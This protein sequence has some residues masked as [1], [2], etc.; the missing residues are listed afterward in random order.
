MSSKFTCPRPRRSGL[1]SAQQVEQEADAEAARTLPD[2]IAPETPCRAG[3]VQVGPGRVPDELRQE[4]RRVDGPGLALVR[5]VCQVGDGALRELLVLP[6]QGQAPR[7][8]P[9][10]LGGRL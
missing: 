9:G 8:L 4:R 3:D 10:R 7:Q 6:V 5:C 1:L 2:V